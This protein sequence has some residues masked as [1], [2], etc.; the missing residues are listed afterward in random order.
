MPFDLRLAEARLSLNLITS[1]EMPSLAW[2]ALEADLD[3]PAIRR[4]A[5]F[6]RPTAFELREV[7]PKAI[8]EMQLVHLKLSDAALRL[9][10]HRAREILRAGKDPLRFTREFERLWIDAGHAHEIVEYGTLDDEVSIARGM[11]QSDQD[12]RIW[13]VQRLEELAARDLHAK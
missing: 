9:A 11:G 1:D 8:E 6:Q 5:A 2:D 13:L 10:N 12:I 3:G 4:L 7:L